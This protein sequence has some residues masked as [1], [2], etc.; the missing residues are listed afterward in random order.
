MQ[1]GDPDGGCLYSAEEP[2]EDRVQQ[3]DTVGGAA[4]PVN[5]LLAPILW[6]LRRRRPGL[7]GDEWHI[8]A[9]ESVIH[10]V[11]IVELT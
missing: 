2:L 8:P 5:T 1:F 11:V 6:I 3:E 10:G 7:V 4:G 9:A